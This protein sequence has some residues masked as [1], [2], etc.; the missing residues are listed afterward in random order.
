MLL[1]GFAPLVAIGTGQ[2]LQIASAGAGSIGNLQFGTIN[3]GY[4]GVLLAGE[5]IGVYAGVRLAHQVNSRILRMMVAVLCIGAA[6]M[7]LMRLP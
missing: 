7:M 5:L 2:V 3:F 6:A 4:A 1:L